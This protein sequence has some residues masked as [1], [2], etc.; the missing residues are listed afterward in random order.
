MKISK[1]SKLIII[2]V[3][4]VIAILC[5][6][7]YNK[8]AGLDEALDKTWSPLVSALQQRYDGVPKIADEVVLYTGKEDSV[9]KALIASDKKFDS[10]NGRE[11]K[12]ETA[13]EVEINLTKLF[14]ESTQRYPGISSH[15]QYTALKKNFEVTSGEMASAMNS[16]NDAVSAYN[17]YVR[18]FPNNLVAVIMGFGYRETYFKKES[19]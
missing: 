5:I 3:A 18:K 4:V 13:N 16:Y 17:T 7:K 11:N 12:V 9:T 1:N 15:Y 8:L 10:A 14:I 6:T 2:V 19:E